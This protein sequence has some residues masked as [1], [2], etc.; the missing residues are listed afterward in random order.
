MQDVMSFFNKNGNLLNE[1]APPLPDRIIK[2]IREHH[3]MTITVSNLSGKEMWPFHAF[4]AFSPDEA[5]FV[6][7]SEENTKHIMMLRQNREDSEDPED[8]ESPGNREN[9]KSRVFPGS[10][11][12]PTNHAIREN[13]ED[14]MSHGNIVAG[15]IALE[16]KQIALLR[17]LQFTGVM[18][19]CGE[20]DLDRCRL[21]YLKRFP[22]AVLKMGEL[23]KISIKEAKL[24]DNRLGFGTK[25]L[26]SR[27]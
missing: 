13:R 4:Y 5:F 27:G 1:T 14:H 17:G 9:P 12:N 18:E 26:W 7:S 2:F 11:G 20:S 22:F 3:L 24:T 15:G 19:P 16:T 10:P 21:L 25:L 23:W 8:R 6:I